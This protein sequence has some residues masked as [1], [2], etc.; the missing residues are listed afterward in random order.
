MVQW[1]TEKVSDPFNSR[2]GVRQTVFSIFNFF[3]VFLKDLLA[4]GEV[5]PR[6]ITRAVEVVGRRGSA[7]GFRGRPV[8]FGGLAG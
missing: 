5:R 1:F 7:A 3:E 6:G 8:E 4:V 2:L